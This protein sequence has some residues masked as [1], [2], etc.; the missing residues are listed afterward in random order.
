MRVLIADLTVLRE[1]KRTGVGHY[2]QELT[3]ALRRVAGEDTIHSFP[4]RWLA[5]RQ[6]WLDAQ[7]QRYETVA[8]RSGVLARIEK[9]VRGKLLAA[10]RTVFPGMRHPFR[11][12]ARR[13][14]CTL[15]HE[16]NYIPH[17]VDLPTV[18]T[19]HDLSVILYPEWHRAETV[20]LFERH[21]ARGLNRCVHLIEV[22]KFTQEQIVRHLGWPLERTSVTYNGRR[23]HLR[24]LSA[25]ECT[26]VLRRLGLEPGYLLHVGTLEPR[27][28]LGML[29]RAYCALPG[30]VRERH[31]LVLA[32]SAGWNSGELHDYLRGAAR[33]ENVRWLGY[34]QDE[35]FAA[36]Y[37][38]ARSLVFPT[39]YEG[40]GMPTVEMLACGG[41]VLA[42]TAGAVAETVGAQAHLI[43]P[44]DEDGWR[45]AMLR[46]CT[47]QDWWQS[48]RRGAQEVGRRFTWTRC[49]HDTLNAYHL[50]LAGGVPVSAAA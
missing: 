21:F 8:R 1:R 3:R 19:I 26:P 31:P 25:E 32:G 44:H 37:S 7:S 30:A 47:D 15:Y 24:P 36:L 46:V 29:L 33:E 13:S 43:D 17:D 27:K 2:T 39:L 28:N 22:S 49:A 34:V 4:G 9:H 11:N 14:G 5:W 16:P 42:S 18:A 6:D 40:F 48:L 10:V 35:D 12:T 41:A 50:A 38:A 20:R 45:D 23:E